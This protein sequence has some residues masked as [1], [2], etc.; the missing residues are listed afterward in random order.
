MI[1]VIG[2]AFVGR[3]GHVGAAQLELCAN[4][5]WS[6]HRSNLHGSKQRFDLRFY[7]TLKWGSR[8]VSRMGGEDAPGDGGLELGGV[9]WLRFGPNKFGSPMGFVER[10]L[11]PNKFGSPW[12]GEG[13]PGDGGLELE[14]VG[15]LWFGPNK[16]G[17]PWF[18]DFF[19]RL[20]CNFGGFYI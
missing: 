8:Q 2:F 15:W 19:V 7:D 9:G 18:G 4:L 5:R 10:W 6:E 3:I 12:F 16:F 11:G 14:G 13:A 20:S 1:C 17:S